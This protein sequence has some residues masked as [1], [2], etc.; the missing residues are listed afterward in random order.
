MSQ[1]IVNFYL[2]NREILLKNTSKRGLTINLERQELYKR[3][4]SQIQTEFGLTLGV[5]KI[6]NHFKH[7]KMKCLSKGSNLNASLNRE[8]R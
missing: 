1:F 2:D 6:K 7:Y 4:M 5:K 8:K 3:L